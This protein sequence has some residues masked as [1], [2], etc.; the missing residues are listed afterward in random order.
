MDNRV[1]I[2]VNVDGNAQRQVGALSGAFA[3]LGGGITSML[4]VAGGLFIFQ[5][6]TSMFRTLSSTLQSVVFGSRQV[7]EDFDT[8]MRRV[9]AV[10]GATADEFNELATA[11]REQARVTQFTARESADAMGF[12]AMAGFDVQQTIGALPGT[13]ELAASANL[14]LASSADIVS[15]VLTGY[16]LEVEQLGRVNDV[17]VG[18]LTNTNVDLLQLGE[19]F[20]YAGGVAKMSGIEFEET[21]AAIGLMGN[22]GFQG[23]MAGTALRGAITRLEKPTK[24]M[25]DTIRKLGLN[26]H[27]SQ[28]Q[29][30]SLHSIVEQ[31]ET[32][33]ADTADMMTLFGLRG[34]PGMASLVEQGADSL[35]NLTEGLRE[36][37]GTASRT[38][39]AMMAGPG[40]AFKILNSVFEDFQISLGTVI[41]DMIISSGILDNLGKLAEQ[42][43]IFFSGFGDVVSIRGEE[44]GAKFGDLW[45]AIQNLLTELGILGPETESAMGMGERA[46][47]SFVNVIIELLDN[48]TKFVNYLTENKDVIKE[49]FEIAKETAELFLGVLR[50]IT[51]ES[52]SI[53]SS[54]KGALGHL[55]EFNR[56]RNEGFRAAQ[57]GDIGGMLSAGFGMIGMN[58]PG[59]GMNGGYIR[60]YQTGGF[61]SGPRMGSGRDNIL[62]RAEEG[63]VILNKKQQD[64]LMRQIDKGETN[65][66]QN[67]Y[68]QANPQ[69]VASDIAFYIEGI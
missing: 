3:S 68:N 69:A 57:G 56:L 65:I 54:I 38:A 29:L 1:T 30:V 58:M 11:A 55:A 17:L 31:L 33:G 2:S 5:G 25:S 28:G 59:G 35:R 52:N 12:L 63:E 14:D 67:F 46:G 20:K 7:A 22:A 45:G 6:I 66:T 41:N 40:G 21:A 18:T 4:A 10:A 43:S 44:I 50:M 60:G 23:S 36:A 49:N 48:A 62:V 51:G 53:G 34:G 15:N 47:D 26:T 24:E 39:E 37:E 32:A 64:N 8:S 27:D 16:G 19:S 9:G 42:A 61:V 13:L